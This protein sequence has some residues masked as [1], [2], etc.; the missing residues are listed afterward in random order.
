MRSYIIVGSSPLAEQHINSYI[1]QNDIKLHNILRFDEKVLIAQA[2]EMR[3]TFSIKQSASEKKV[4]IVNAEMTVD[5]QNSLLKSIEELPE[6]ITI[7]ICTQSLEL[8]LPTISSRCFIVS[9]QKS[10]IENKAIFTEL[11]MDYYFT[12]KIS[13][14]QLVEKILESETDGNILDGVILSFRELLT[15]AVLRSE[16]VNS[17]GETY[18]AMNRLLGYFSLLENNNVNLR[19][20]L[21]NTL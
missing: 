4:I 19:L 7:F 17:L 15:K 5:S 13:K 20:T 3:R 12:S 14:M 21:E 11:L 16:R 10:E 8:I 1:Q 6:N 2:K 9:L 18:S